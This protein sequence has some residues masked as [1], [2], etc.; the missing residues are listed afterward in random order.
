MYRFN[1]PN[2]TCGGCARSITKALQ[3]VD[4]GAGIETD[5]STHEVR[6]VSAIDERAF[7]DALQDAGYPHQP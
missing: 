6:V 5:P 7:L 1:V 4:P 2:M 3:G